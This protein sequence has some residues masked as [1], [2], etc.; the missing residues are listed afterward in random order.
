VR[1]EIYD[2]AAEQLPISFHHVHIFTADTLAIQ[3]WYVKT[4]G[5][6]PGKRGPFDTAALPGVDISFNKEDKPLAKTAGRSI[7]HIGFEVKGLDAYIKKLQAMGIT[8]DRP[9]Q[10]SPAKPTIMTAYLT[11][12]VGTQIELTENLAPAAR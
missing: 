2:N 11:D 3:A 12:P 1:V 5:A 10:K 6:V 9:L 4:F 8:L 7:D